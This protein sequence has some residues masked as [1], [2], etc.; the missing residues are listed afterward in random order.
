MFVWMGIIL[1]GAI[2]PA[3]YCIMAWRV[4]K[5]RMAWITAGFGGAACVFVG[6]LCLRAVF[7]T[8]GL[9]VFMFY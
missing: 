5:N 3:V 9:S 2:V 6:C 1:I 8:I 4:G 7:Y